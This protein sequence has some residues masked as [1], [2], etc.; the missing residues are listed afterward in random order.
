MIVIKGDNSYQNIFFQLVK[1]SFHRYKRKK[2]R[3]KEEKQKQ[4]AESLLKN[5]DLNN[6]NYK[7]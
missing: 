2:E 3:E 6:G 1:I 4:Q 7:V 5:G